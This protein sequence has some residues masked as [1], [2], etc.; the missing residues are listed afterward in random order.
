[1]A[2]SDAIKQRSVWKPAFMV[3]LLMVQSRCMV[4]ALVA[5][6]GMNGKDGGMKRDQ[7]WERRK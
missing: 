2:A 4:K 6:N 1:V 7:L 3:V 5:W